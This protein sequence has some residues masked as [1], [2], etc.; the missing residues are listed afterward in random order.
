MKVAEAARQSEWKQPSFMRELFLGNLRL[1][2]V[3]PYLSLSENHP[4]S[5][6]STG[7]RGVPAQ[8]SQPGG[9]DVA[10]EYP[11]KVIE[12][13]RKLGASAGRYR[14]NMEASDSSIRE[15]WSSSAASTAT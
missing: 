10:G 8:R 12:G 1:D 5:R 13:S 14:E 3:H 15:S 2:L 11:P 7:A 4:N 9:I 6:A